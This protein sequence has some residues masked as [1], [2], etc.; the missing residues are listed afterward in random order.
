MALYSWLGPEE[1]LSG[2]CSV[3]D[4][5]IVGF[6]NIENGVRAFGYITIKDYVEHGIEGTD[7]WE[8]FLLDHSSEWV[9]RRDQTKE[10]FWVTPDGEKVFGLNEGVNQ[11]MKRFVAKKVTE[12]LEYPDCLR[13]S[14]SIVDA[15]KEYAGSIK[16]YTGDCVCH[17][18]ETSDKEVPFPWFEMTQGQF[19]NNCF[20]CSCGQRWWRFDL[21]NEMWC[22][23]PDDKAWEMFMKY[24]GEAV[25]FIGIMKDDRFDGVYLEQTLCDQGLIPLA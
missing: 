5:T 18:I 12:Y 17:R 13:N 24:G 11:A 23:V 25:Q 2:G 7:P 9:A 10:A 20:E 22:K 8:A 4:M 6:H 3:I 21:Q 19:P 16:A 14:E 15:P 1:S